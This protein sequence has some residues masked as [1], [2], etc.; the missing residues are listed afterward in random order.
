MIEKHKKVIY[1]LVMLNFNNKI[2]QN[3]GNYKSNFENNYYN[4]SFK[5]LYILYLLFLNFCTC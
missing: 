2:F 1:I 4:Y 5:I 3:H